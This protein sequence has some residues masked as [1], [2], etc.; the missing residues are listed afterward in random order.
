MKA[1]IYQ[2]PKNFE[3]TEIPTPIPNRDEI[4]IKVD[5]CAI[6]GSDLHTYTKGVYVDPGHIMGHEFGGTIAKLGEDCKDMGLY[7]GQKVVT[8][9]TIACGHCVMCRKGLPNVCKNALT[10]T[11]AYG[12]P[13][14]FAQ[15]VLQGGNGFIYPLPD[16]VDTKEGAMMEPLAVAIHAVKRAKLNLND[17]A[18]VLGA[19]TLGILAAQVLKTI[20]NIRVILV[21]VS[22]K[23][24]E[25]AKQVGI[26]YTINPNKVNDVV[27][28]IAA[29]TGP[30]FYGPG[31]AQADLVF[32]CAGV[33]Q[34]VTQ[35]LRIV[36]HGGTV[37]TVALADEPAPV[38]IT[39]I[40]QKEINLLGS[41]AYINEFEEAIS[42]VS[43]GKIH[44]EPL[45][46]HIYPLNQIQEAFETQLDTSKS[47]KVL[48]DC[49][50]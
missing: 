9:P 2:G 42:L 39:V 8:N 3:V 16:S 18:V 28:E 34:T 11:L 43:S 7:V 15:Y 37:V 41:Y 35:A 14:A 19:G 48:I 5:Y 10:G 45:I 13:G 6:C 24:L 30:G 20:G 44:L 12:K 38:D 29:M 26:D 17:T 23:R 40:T 46:T 1:A 27:A 4:L 50:S 33:P 31:G 36:R 47:V 32:E 22:E 21:D 49:R 25:V